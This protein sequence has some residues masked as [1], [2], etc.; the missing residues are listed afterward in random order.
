MNSRGRK[1]KVRY[2]Q[3]MP[4]VSQFSPR[5]KSGR[6]DAVELTIDQFEAIRLADFQGYHHVEAAQFMGL[7][8][9]SFGRILKGARHVVANA[10]V[11][12]KTIYIRIS[13]VQV[14]VTRKILP[15]KASFQV[16]QDV[17]RK[18]GQIRH[19]ILEYPE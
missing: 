19:V 4:K 15:H 9:P 1:K 10:L 16:A 13:N 17:N 7:S 14:G 6:P 8:R 11:N 18:E 3:E 2:I 12:G 5:G